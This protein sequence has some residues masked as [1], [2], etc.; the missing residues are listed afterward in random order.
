MRKPFDSVNVGEL[1]PS[2]LH[3]SKSFL[4]YPNYSDSKRPEKRPLREMLNSLDPSIELEMG[5]VSA[6]MNKLDFEMAYMSDSE[7]D[8]VTKIRKKLAI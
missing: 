7:R 5:T 8:L 4:E 3:M 2:G 6:E 1:H